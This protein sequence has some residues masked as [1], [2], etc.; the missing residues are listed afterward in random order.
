MGA[1]LIGCRATLL[2]LVGTARA[3]P[4]LKDHSSTEAEWHPGR[5]CPSPPPWSKEEV[6]L[7]ISKVQLWHSQSPWPPGLCLGHM[8][9]DVPRVPRLQ[10]GLDLWEAVLQQDLLCAT[11]SLPT[12]HPP[13]LAVASRLLSGQRPRYTSCGGRG[14]SPVS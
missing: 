2:A 14:R 4:F 1:Q 7:G 9:P 3:R 11:I 8:C 5:P 6:P 10:H 12:G 13:W